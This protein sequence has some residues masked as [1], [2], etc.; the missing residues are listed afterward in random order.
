MK[1]PIVEHHTAPIPSL[2][3]RAGI[4][5]MRLMAVTW[6]RAHPVEAAELPS[7][8]IE[9]LRLTLEGVS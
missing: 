8:N 5:P 4:H 2:L 9:L 7:W 1:T 6:C 3:E